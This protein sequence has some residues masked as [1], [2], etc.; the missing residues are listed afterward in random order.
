MG[1]GLKTRPTWIARMGSCVGVYPFDEP[2]QTDQRQD[3]GNRVFVC[4]T[5]SEWTDERNAAYGYNYQFL[6]NSRVTAGR[7]HWYPTKRSR[8]QTFDR[9]VVAAD[10]LGTAASF[11]TVARTAYENDGNTAA[12]L[13]NEAYTLD[14]PRLSPTGDISVSPNRNGAHARHSSR[15]NVLFA[16]THG[17]TM[18]LEA[19]GYAVR[20]DGTYEMYGSGATPT[21]AGEPHNR[22]FGGTGRDETPPPLPS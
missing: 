10:S 3:F 20:G 22:L 12:A 21:P 16:D 1:N 13:G 11:P 9:T 8:L 15:V 2:S 19:M 14:P 7:Y 17:A 5:V 6:G 4:P 18:R